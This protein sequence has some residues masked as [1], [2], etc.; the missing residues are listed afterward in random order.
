MLKQLVL[1]AALVT[2]ATTAQ[3]ACPVP[4]APAASEKPARPTPPPVPVCAKVNDCGQGVAAEY[5]RQV[6]A[7]NAAARDFQKDT[8][9]YVARLNAFVAAAEAY[10]KC[11]VA[12]LN[13][14]P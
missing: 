12:E 1:T 5:N 6:N 10:A 13:G 8:Q 2:A 4:V 14:V 11:E 9:A 7:F 3:A